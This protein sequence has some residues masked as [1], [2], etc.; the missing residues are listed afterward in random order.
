MQ[1]I[2]HKVMESASCF[3]RLEWRGGARRES[4]GRGK[5]LVGE[6]ED[7][8]GEA[9]GESFFAV[10][11]LEHAVLPIEQIRIR[12][13]KLLPT[14]LEAGAGHALADQK[15]ISPGNGLVMELRLA[16][17]HGEARERSGKMLKCFEW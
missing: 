13:R 6:E 10:V 12:R 17:G 15:D 16:I 4:R 11:I 8:P 2:Y 5:G 14:L 9:G 7:A 3:L 1:C